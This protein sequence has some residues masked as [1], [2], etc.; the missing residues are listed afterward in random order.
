MFTNYRKNY[1][2]HRQPRHELPVTAAAQVPQAARGAEHELAGEVRAPVCAA[3]P[4]LLEQRTR[5]AHPAPGVAARA[6]SLATL[7]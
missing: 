6:A 3:Q 5:S 1:L 7:L 2:K 4:G